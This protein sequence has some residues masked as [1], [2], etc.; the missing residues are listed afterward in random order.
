MNFRKPGYPGF[1]YSPSFDSRLSENPG[2]K[3]LDGDTN[4]SQQWTS[5]N[6]LSSILFC[7]D[8]YVSLKLMETGCASK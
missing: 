3:A 4:H 7:H 1:F 6:V 5:E 8:N 2:W